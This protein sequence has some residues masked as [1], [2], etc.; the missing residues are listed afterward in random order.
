M[1]GLLVGVSACDDILGGLYDTPPKEAEADRGW[2]FYDA[3]THHGRLYINVVS[4]KDW[5]YIDLHRRNTNV[6]S[7]PARLTTKWDGRSGISFQQVTF[8]STFKRKNFVQTDSMPSPQHWDLAL[9]HYDVRTNE[10]S[11]L[12]TAYHSLEQLPRGSEQENLLRQTFSSDI[13]SEHTCYYDL[14]AIYNY[15]IGYHNSRVNPVLSRWMNM[16]VSNPPPVYTPSGR[17]YLLRLSDGSVA[18]LHFVNYRN[19]AGAKGYVT[20]DYI[21]PY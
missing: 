9:H 11:A 17:V 3:S 2:V 15:Y 18:A 21:Y 20:L 8:P 19:A 12:E 10:G 16:D 1:P 7:I 13:W 4:Y 5:T 6:L 14:T